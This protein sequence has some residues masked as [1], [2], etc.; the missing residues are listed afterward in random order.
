MSDY[1]IHPEDYEHSEGLVNESEAQRIMNTDTTTLDATALD[2]LERLFAAIP[3][4][5]DTGH[6][7][8]IEYEPALFDAAP[9][10]IAAAR[11]NAFLRLKVESVESQKA[12]WDQVER[13]L[14]AENAK[15]RTR[16]SRAEELIKTA[17]G[18]T[19][20]ALN[21]DE[22]SY[23]TADAKEQIQRFADD[24]RALLAGEGGKHE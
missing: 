6:P 5:C 4:Q 18:G 14:K 21:C 19:A 20:L 8:F 22:S 24:I 17:E 11:E 10:L 23:P 9:A 1:D 2:E 3:E 16:L 7:A 12:G 15:L 13:E